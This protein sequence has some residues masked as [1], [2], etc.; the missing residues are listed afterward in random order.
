MR[1]KIRMDPQTGFWK[2]D[3]AAHAHLDGDPIFIGQ[4]VFYTHAAAL[5]W[6]LWRIGLTKSPL[7]G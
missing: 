4:R 1:A 7:V 5:Q 2:V 6:T 3:L